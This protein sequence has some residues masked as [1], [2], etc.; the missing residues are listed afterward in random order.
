MYDFYDL[1]LVYHANKIFIK[2]FD[3]VF[4]ETDDSTTTSLF[5]YTSTEVLNL[6]LNTATF[7]ATN[8][9][10]LNDSKEYITGVMELRKYLKNNP[11]YYHMLTLLNKDDGKSFP[12]LYTVS[13]SKEPD[14]LHQWITYA[15][16]SGVAI[17]LDT[18]LFCYQEPEWVLKQ[19]LCEEEKIGSLPIG[20][21]KPLKYLSD[22]FSFEETLAN[23]LSN[24]NDL[25]DNILEQQIIKEILLRMISSY[26]KNN[27]FKTENEYRIS[28][29]PVKEKEI[30][31]QIKYFPYKGTLRPFL[32]L[33]F[34]Q[35]NK[36]NSLDNMMPIKSIK[37]GPSGKQQVVFN[38]IVHRIKYGQN[39][40]YNYSIKP[41]SLVNRLV[42]FIEA[43]LQWLV[44]TTKFSFNS[45]SCREATQFTCSSDK[46]LLND[47][48]TQLNSREILNELGNP[49]K[50]FKEIEV[51]VDYIILNWVET[52]KT[53]L[54]SLKNDTGRK[55][56][57]AEYLDFNMNNK[58]LPSIKQVIN[59]ID[60]EFF[61]SK[62]GILID[63]S[64]I[65]YIF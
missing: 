58:L 8:I 65:P 14:S 34:A 51:I 33:S 48:K 47:I 11:Q 49:S 32:E 52:N 24:E 15:K 3:D 4:L 27:S 63:K 61:L 6:L 39:K 56:Y 13:F 5:H 18:T 7:R 28:C 59:E 1:H 36:Y 31:S 19:P 23:F 2:I 12:G 17:E 30:Y 38:S 62:E 37:I 22:N 45:S 42:E 20:I 46:N 64:T 44:K 29:F 60:N 9:F 35:R 16:E 10:Y 40:V 41:E 55:I 54:T 43:I 21:L 26:I 25:K 57:S 50:T 53:Y